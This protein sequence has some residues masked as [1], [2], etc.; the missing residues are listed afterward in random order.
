MD[1]PAGPDYVL[2]PGDVLSIDI[3]GGVSQRLARIVDREGRISLPEA[4]PMAVAGLTLADAQKRVQVC[5]SRYSR[6]PRLIS[7]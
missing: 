3:W 4:G 7:R 1:M 6:I 2:G 5:Y